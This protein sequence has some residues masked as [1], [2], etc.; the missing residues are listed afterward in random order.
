MLNLFSSFA[1][2]KAASQEAEA[3][4]REQ[5]VWER[6]VGELQSRCTTL[7]EEKYEALAKVRESVQVAEEAALQ[8]D[9]VTLSSYLSAPPP[10]IFFFFFSHW[11]TLLLNLL[12]CIILLTSVPSS[13][14]PLKCVSVRILSLQALLRE[15][16]KAEELEKTKEA[17]KQLIHDAA[18]RTRKEVNGSLSRNCWALSEEVGTALKLYKI[19]TKHLRIAAYSAKCP[20]CNLLCVWLKS[21]FNLLNVSHHYLKHWMISR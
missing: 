18:V 6:K 3:V 7:E 15:K 20:P 14:C 4:R 8:K 13:L 9:Q 12:S 1:R 11:R 19:S 16:Q 10:P 17:I 5:T 21:V 2:L